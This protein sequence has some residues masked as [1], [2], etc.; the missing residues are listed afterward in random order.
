MGYTATAVL[1][2][3]IL[4]NTLGGYGNAIFI[5]SL[6]FVPGLLVVVFTKG[7]DNKLAETSYNSHEMTDMIP[8]IV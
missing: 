5:F 6:V 4:V 7:Q 2:I 1:F 8:D 3:G